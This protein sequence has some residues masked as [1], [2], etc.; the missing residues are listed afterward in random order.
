MADRNINPLAAAKDAFPGQTKIIKIKRTKRM[1]KV[2]KAV[3][4]FVAKIEQAHEAAGK[5]KLRF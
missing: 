1:K 2:H 3:S 5:S 4:A